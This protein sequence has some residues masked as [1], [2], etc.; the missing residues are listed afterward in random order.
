MKRRFTLRFGRWGV[1]LGIVFAAS[2]LMAITVWAA[3]GLPFQ[4]DS[5][6]QTAAQKQAK[7]HQVEAQETAA[8]KTPHGS[9]PQANQANTAPITSCPNPP[10]TTGILTTRDTGGFHDQIT[11]SAIVAPNGGVPF[12]YVVYAGA[13]RTNL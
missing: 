8:A 12:Y 9:K 13:L 10:W 11:N 3:G 7:I 1:I 4:Q 2:M 5:G 6:P